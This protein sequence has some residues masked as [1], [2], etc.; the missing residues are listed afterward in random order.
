MDFHNLYQ[1][2]YLRAAAGSIRVSLAEPLANAAAVLDQFRRAADSGAGLVVFPELTLTGASAQDLI[3]QD[4]VLARVEEA[5]GWLASSTASFTPVL[6]VG[7][8]LRHRHRLYNTAVVMQRGRILGVVAKLQANSAADSDEGR[9]FTA[10][11]SLDQSIIVADQSVPFGTNLVFEASDQT[12]FVLGVEIGSD[13]ELLVPPSTTLALAGAT[14]I[15]NP[16]ASPARVGQPALRQARA[17]A[18]SQRLVAGYVQANGGAGESTNELAWDGHC[19][20]HEAGQ[21]LIET[22][23]FSPDP[24]LVVADLDLAGM[25]GRR[26]RRRSFTSP[27]TWSA[28]Q[29]ED[30]R[31]VQFMLEPPAGDLGLRRPITR[32]PYLP[33]SDD[34]IDQACAD[35]V[36]IQTVA[37]QQRLLAIGNPK[38]VIGVS[39]GLDS[40]LALLVAVQALDRIGR[41][42]S[43]ILAFTMPG[44]ATSTGTRNNAIALAEALEVNLEVLDITETARLMLTNLGHPFAGGE[45][46][47]DITFE[48]VQAGLRTDYLFRF[49]NQRGGMVLGTGDLSELALGWCTY[50]V[51]D[52]MSHYN[53]NAGVPKTFIQQIL[54]WMIRTG[55]FRREVRETLVSITE[56]PISP[57][58]VPGSDAAPI[59][60]TEAAI[61]PYQLQ[62]FNL[63]HTLESGMGPAKLAFLAWHTWRD[64]DGYWP[65]TVAEWQR[66][67]YDLAEIRHWLGVFHHRFFGISQFKRSAAPNGPAV[68]GVGALSP[69]GDW[70]APSD[71][72]AAAWAAELEGVPQS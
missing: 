46:V 18:A 48:N 36:S 54:G 15:A 31:R 41:P 52:Q 1:H 3:W 70:R 10:G 6:V 64:T 29:P 69:R 47:Y 11:S 62:D 44:F 61:G 34:Q 71:S 58:L 59:Q 33:A 65:S 8:P 7:A 55:Q 21:L 53:V 67:S 45:P 14:V 16:S 50:G 13:A 26:L 57:E 12:D 25:V 72:S 56:G 37:L 51:G 43:D 49:A 42:R 19:L 9:W 30:V 24:D 27:P 4:A 22:Q 23:P 60:S 35:A 38:I 28:S 32:Y 2:G 39:G 68:L 20:I 63:F 66:R 40:T 17:G 5:L